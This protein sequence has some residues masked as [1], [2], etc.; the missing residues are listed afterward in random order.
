MKESQIQKCIVQ[1]LQY[2]ENAR[3]LY[4][5]RNNTFVGQI[6]RRD[7]SVGYMRQGKSG[8]ADIIVFM[9]LGRT[10]FVEV[11]AEK[12]RQSLAQEQF[13]ERLLSLGFQYAIVRSIDDLKAVL[14]R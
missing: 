14:E 1:Y 4:F 6:R 3:K 10:I 11:K 7:G 8:A 9:P 2:M 12:G 5:I 13:Q